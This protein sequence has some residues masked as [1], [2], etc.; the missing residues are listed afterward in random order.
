MVRCKGGCRDC[1]DSL[2]REEDTVPVT[3]GCSIIKQSPGDGMEGL[4]WF[5]KLS[6]EGTSRLGGGTAEGGS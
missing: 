6:L 5:W 1:G 2:H 4:L 3:S